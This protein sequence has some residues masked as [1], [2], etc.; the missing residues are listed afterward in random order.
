MRIDVSDVVSVPYKITLL[1]NGV[2]SVFSTVSVSVPYKI[3]L[4]SNEYSQAIFK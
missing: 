2:K 1:S 3:T 4:L